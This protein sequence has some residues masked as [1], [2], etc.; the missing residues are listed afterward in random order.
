MSETCMKGFFFYSDLVSIYDIHT[1]VDQIYLSPPKL[2][3]INMYTD[4]A[5]PNNRFNVSAL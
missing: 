2:M 5:A 1:W 3:A 4:F